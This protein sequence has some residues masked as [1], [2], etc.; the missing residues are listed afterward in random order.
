[1]H[2][3]LIAVGKLKE[4]YLQAAYKEYAKRLSAYCR[5]HLIEI[6]DEKDND[7]A[8][9][10]KTIEGERILSK[11]NPRDVVITLDPQGQMSDSVAFA[12]RLAAYQLAGQSRLCFIIGGSNGLS[13]A[14]LKRAQWSVSFSPMT[15]PHQLFR[16]I[17]LE[18]IYRAFKINKG[19][20]Y[21]K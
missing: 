4:T 8:E 13:G 12:E 9:K 20:T 11:I 1:M 16:I 7:A 17:L 10:S 18:Q 21:H 3:T 15:F 5:F 19:E 6:K 2:I 14:V